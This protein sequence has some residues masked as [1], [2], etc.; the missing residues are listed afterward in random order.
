MR[1][2]AT[3]VLVLAASGLAARDG[4]KGGKEPAF[5]A[6]GIQIE[7]D[8]GLRD[9]WEFSGFLGVQSPVDL[10]IRGIALHRSGAPS[11]DRWYAFD[12]DS[13]IIEQGPLGY[14]DYPKGEKTRFEM[15]LGDQWRKIKRIRI[16]GQA[17][18][19]VDPGI[20]PVP[21]KRPPLR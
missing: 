4:D 10:T 8:K 19:V 14:Q 20:T 16:V 1:W 9:G 15:L 18:P 7:I 11:L 17:I 13:V 21:T 2:L 3:G 12:K 5:Q 6:E